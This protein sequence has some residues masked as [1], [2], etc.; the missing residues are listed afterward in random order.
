[1]SKIATWSSGRIPIPVS[2]TRISIAPSCCTTSTRTA[3]PGHLDAIIELVPLGRE[4]LRI[5]NHLH[6]AEDDVQG[7]SQLVRHGRDELGFE[8]VDPLE[9][10]HQLRVRERGRRELRDAPRDPLPLPGE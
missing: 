9:L 5:A 7:R 1:M 10:R 6:E 8:P 2:A 3:P 4:E